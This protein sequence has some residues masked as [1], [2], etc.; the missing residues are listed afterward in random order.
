MNDLL[1]TKKKKNDGR[2][3]GRVSGKRKRE[4]EKKGGQLKFFQQEITNEFVHPILSQ[5]LRP[6]ILKGLSTDPLSPGY[7]SLMTGN[8]ETLV[9]SKPEPE[10]KREPGGS[11]SISKT[12]QIP[13]S[14][15]L[16]HHCR[17][18]RSSKQRIR[19]QAPACLVQD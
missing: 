4:E 3:A 12:K 7:K 5:S 6:Q 2:C 9:S 13:F 19:G 17:V 18:G 16:L 11:S 8:S 10:A 14:P 15:S 1:F